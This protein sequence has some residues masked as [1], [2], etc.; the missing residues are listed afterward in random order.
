VARNRNSVF[1]VH[2]GTRLPMRIVAKT[3]GAA[4]RIAFR[5]LIR[6]GIL[7]RQPKSS[8]DDG[9]EGVIISCGAR[10]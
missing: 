4:A 3:A 6:K 2:I 8:D 10:G 9:W 5:S 7:K 1:D